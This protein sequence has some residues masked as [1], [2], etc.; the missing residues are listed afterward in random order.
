MPAATYRFLPW[1]RRG[2]ADRVVDVDDAGPLPARGKV[3]VGLTI[4]SL[5]EA[6]RNLAVLG[7]GDAVGVDPRLVVRTSPRANSL[8]VEP[9][10]FAHIEFDPPDFP[11]LLTPARSGPAERLRP[12][13]VLVVVD[14]AVVEAPRTERGVPLPVLE[15]PAAAVARELPDLHESWA[16]AHVQAMAPA[17][18]VD[19]AAELTA[20]PAMNVSRI[21]APRRLEPGKRYAACLV[22]AFDAGVRRG[23]GDFP[24]GN[25]PLGPAWPAPGGRDVR[26][27][28]YFHWEFATGSQG[29]FESLARRLRP[30]QAAESLGVE[31]MYVGAAGPE[32]PAL[33]LEVPGAVLEMDG[34]LRAPK[35]SSA[36]LDDVAE[37]LRDALRATL[38]AAAD[39]AAEG[40]DDAAPAFG[41]PIYGAFHARQHTIAGQG[42]AWLRELNLD[43]RARAAAGLG[44]EIE[45]ANQE[46]LVHWCWQQVGRILE[47][48]RLMSRA[49]LSLELL[50]RVHDRHVASL[51]ADRLL[52]VTA[53]LH[54]RTKQGALT[55]TATIARSSLPDAVGDPAL[56]RLTSP[57]RPLLRAALTRAGSA[58]EPARVRLV[59]G[60]ATGA[61]DVDPS[62]FVPDGLLGAR[63]LEAVAVPAAGDAPISLADAGLSV[64]VPASLVRDLRT[65]VQ[66]V[67][68]HL[69]PRVQPRTD[70]RTTGMVGSAHLR[71][72]RAETAGDARLGGGVLGGVRGTVGGVGSGLE[73]IHDA[74]T[75]GRLEF[76]LDRVDRDGQ[77]GATVPERSFVAFDVAEAAATI[78][79]RTDPRA[80]V[81]R[82]LA[83]MLVAGDDLKVLDDNPPT[84]L[85]VAPT[86]DRVMA[87][88][89]LNLP[90]YELLARLD[91][92]RFLPGVGAIPDEAI[93]LLETNPRFIEALLVGLNSEVNSELLWRKFPTDQGGTP[94]RSF[95]KWT[96]GNPD[97]APIHDWSEQNGLGANAR[98]GPGGQIAL[99]VRGRLLRR[100]PNTAIYAWRSAADGT[101]RNPPEP[102]DLELPAFAGVLGD[103]I[104]FV[105]FNLTEVQL[106]EGEGWFFVL[107]EQPTEPRFG[108]DEALNGS[109][110]V[111]TSWSD[112][113]WEHVGTSGGDHLKIDGNPLVG[114][115]FGDARFV[116]HA[117]HLASIALQKPFRVAVHAR[118]LVEGVTPPDV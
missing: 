46:E 77:I 45:R 83:T 73:P 7:P 64:T 40:A 111:L 58:A 20:K 87:A 69:K 61:L 79:A 26:L 105:G 115:Q 43:P 72:T 93:T 88:P 48:N 98:G 22:P 6:R 75:I 92:N 57:A 90:V 71:R 41:P 11:W 54:A 74:G 102:G 13:C 36:K 2:L 91:T 51:P 19:V 101:L 116:D 82:R 114:T 108:F 107:Q 5:P 62:R 25:A 50:A 47:A 99:L 12:W 39:Q 103:D 14:L 15:V 27:P 96:D 112:A 97:I 76:A 31:P 1:A 28:V 17:G 29:D 23:L 33:A 78:L 55:I 34:A 104:A 9:N 38:N 35:R 113:T 66:A 18:A 42:P 100:Y 86:Q 118:S 70:L 10:Y 85:V 106:A 65:E 94:M 8:D 60:L 32:L 52:G 24:D 30:F 59:A 117:A 37:T 89:E 21:L 63:R 95:W 109:L 49:R 80:T 110:P 44:A 68:D 3:S 81:P 67:E 84:G 53:P 16:W 56:R 4:S